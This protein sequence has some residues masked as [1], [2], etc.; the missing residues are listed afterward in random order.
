VGVPWQY[1]AR[2][3][4]DPK[5]GYKPA[6]EL[7]WDAIAG[8]PDNYVDATDPLMVQ[9]IDP[10]TGTS[11]ITG[12]PLA[13]PSSTLPS[14]NKSNGH[15]WNI[16]AR[17]DLQY[18]CTFNLATPRDC[19]QATTSCD[20]GEV[21]GMNNPLCQDDTG[22]YGKMQYRAKAYPAPRVLSVLKGMGPR[23]AVASICAS[24]VTDQKAP[25][26]GYRPAI[27]ALIE[28]MKLYF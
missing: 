12:A 1:I 15:E 10:R 27:A 21:D 18:T 25:D 22:Q 28:R 3:P 20:C 19:A 17:N 14:A 16:L 2:D 4:N 9:S 5:K 11:P 8:D 24:N 13:P 23:A 7:A 26:F 6:M